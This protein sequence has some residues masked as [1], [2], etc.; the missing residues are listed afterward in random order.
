MVAAQHIAGLHALL[1]ATQPIQ[2]AHPHPV[3]LALGDRSDLHVAADGDLGVALDVGTQHRFQLGLVEHVHLREPVGGAELGVARDFGE[4][5]H[6]WVDQP[7]TQ[8]G[9]AVGGELLADA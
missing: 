4:H 9:P 2:E 6:L 3:G 5:L 8:R 7:K 1:A